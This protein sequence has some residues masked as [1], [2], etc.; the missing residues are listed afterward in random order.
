MSNGA[1]RSAGVVV[2]SPAGTSV[3]RYT[4][5]WE[6]L[7]SAV[8]HQ[9]IPS[10]ILAC[11]DADTAHTRAVAAGAR[12]LAPVQADF[13]G[14]RHGLVQCPFGH[15]WI[16]TSRTEDL[17]ADEIAQRFRDWLAAGEPLDLQP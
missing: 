3:G 13:S 4:G 14:A 10:S 9:E 2:E 6:V 7:D 12:S 17:S 15:R 11:V 5:Y 1:S 16:L 8:L